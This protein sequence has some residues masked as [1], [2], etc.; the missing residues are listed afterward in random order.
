[1]M[2]CVPQFW[3]FPPNFRLSFK[4]RGVNGSMRYEMIASS[5]GCCML[6][7]SGGSYPGQVAMPGSQSKLCFV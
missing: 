6:G 1:M 4:L 5:K 3:Y 2:F 7:A